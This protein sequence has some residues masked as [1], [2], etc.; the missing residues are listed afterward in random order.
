MSGVRYSSLTGEANVKD[1]GLRAG[2]EV[3]QLY[4]VPPQAKQ[5]RSLALQG[6]RRV[7]LASEASTSSLSLDPRMLSQVDPQGVRA[8]PSGGYRC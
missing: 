5:S 2:D 1:S 6:V 3:A 4:L 8:A 7:H